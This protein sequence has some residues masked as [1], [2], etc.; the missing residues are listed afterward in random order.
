MIMLNSTQLSRIDLNLLVLFSVVLEE[1]HV[2]RAA[3]RLNLTP[4]AVSHGLGR[5]RRVLNDPLFLRTP[6]GV[7]PTDRARQL[8]E[9]VAD[10]LARVGSVIATAAP[11]DP[12]TSRRR[13][14]IGAPDGAS[15]VLLEPLF[16]RLRKQ[17]PGIDIG[18][19]H[20]MPEQ[21]ITADQ[22]WQQGLEMLEARTID[23]AVLPLWEVPPR[24]VARS[25]YEEDFVA[26]M[27]KGH[28]FARNPNLYAFCQ[29]D[30]ALVSLSGDPHGFIDE[31]LA[32]R[33]LKRRVVL[34]VPSFMMALAHLAGSDLIASLPRR[35]VQH[36]GAR[37]GLVAAELP[38]PRK[39]DPIQAITTKPALMD[40]GVSWLMDIVAECTQ[41]QPTLRVRRPR[42]GKG[43]SPR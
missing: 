33:G 8:A 38:L 14:R 17:A 21:P 25:L 29:A 31:L 28:A 37:F 1:G 11:F 24:F 3:G 2:A 22:A 16:A 6:R 9:P 39:P 42:P 4:S 12:S 5:L 15:A 26:A 35:L 19:V 10:V 32:K 7:V 34:T 43:F 20:L 23:I 30:H 18:L 27:R 40:A 13:F 36:H 41:D